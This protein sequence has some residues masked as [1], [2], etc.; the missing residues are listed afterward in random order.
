M[1]IESLVELFNERAAIREHDGGM[2]KEDAERMAREDVEAYR[3]R[4]ECFS[5]VR[6]YCEKGSEAVKSYLLQ[7]EKHRGSEP[8]QRLRNDALEMLKTGDKK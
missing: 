1:P 4:C 2:S 7:V 6:M 3:H 8:A 5:V